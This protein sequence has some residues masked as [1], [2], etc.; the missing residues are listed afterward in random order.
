MTDN[1]IIED[2]AGNTLFEGDY[3]ECDSVLEANRCSCHNQEG[4]CSDCDFTGYS[5]EFSIYWLDNE[6]SGIDNVY[7]FI[8]Y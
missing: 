8:N 5:G 4:Y 6:R 7:D 2:W 1:I 3:R